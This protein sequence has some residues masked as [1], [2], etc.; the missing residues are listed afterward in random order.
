MTV[1]TWPVTLPQ[2]FDRQ[3]FVMATGDGRLLSKT[4]TGPG[5][6]RRRSTAMPTPV[7]GGMTITMVQKDTLIAFVRDDLAGGTLPFNFPEPTGGA[8]TVLMRYAEEGLPQYQYLGGPL[9]RAMQKME[10]MP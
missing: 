3:G 9:W 10:I 1:P 6:M 4:D 8:G 7:Q 2:V 5:K